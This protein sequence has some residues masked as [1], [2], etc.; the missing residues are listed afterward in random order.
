MRIIK[1]YDQYLKENKGVKMNED[2]EDIE[3]PNMDIEV[4][5]DSVEDDIES[6]MPGDEP[7][8]SEVSDEFEG[9]DEGEE[10]EGNQYIGNKM[11]REL[12]SKLG[13]EVVDNSVMYDGKKINFFSETE[14]Y[15]VDRQKFKTVEEVVNYLQGSS[16][17]DEAPVR[18]EDPY[19]SALKND[20]EMVEDEIEEPMMMEKRSY[21]TTR[22]F[23]SFK[24]KK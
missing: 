17:Q 19:Q 13:A 23:E 9:E 21:R 1:K 14:M 8:P 16:T 2:F 24:S 3:E 18:S 4:N 11:L 10:E 15:H 6:E 22:K 20:D 5:H 7:L 12:A